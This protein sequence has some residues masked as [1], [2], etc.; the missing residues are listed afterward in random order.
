VRTSIRCDEIIPDAGAA[1]NQVDQVEALAESVRLYGVLRPVLV[2]P[3]SNGYVIVHGER[4]WRAARMAGLQE[5]P[6]LIVQDIA[7]TNGRA[8][9]ATVSP[10]SLSED[11]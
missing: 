7:Q 11:D 2:R 6:V 10:G 3:V 1:A 9:E 8:G 4:R 5:I